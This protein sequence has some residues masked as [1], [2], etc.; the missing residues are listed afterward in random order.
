MPQQ[1]HPEES[2]NK[3]GLLFFIWQSLRKIII[4]MIFEILNEPFHQ[5]VNKLQWAAG[6]LDVVEW[7]F[8]SER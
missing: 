4:A 2:S 3:C 5:S 8:P 7:T 6:K 1:L